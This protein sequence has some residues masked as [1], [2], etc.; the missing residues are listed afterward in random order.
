M[1][2]VEDLTPDQIA[3]FRETFNGFDQDGD[4]KITQDEFIH[5]MR[6]W[7]QNPTEEE[8]QQMFD[9]VDKDR[10]GYIEFD[11]YLCLM[12]S[13]LQKVDTEDDY[14]NAFKEFD[15]DNDGKITKDELKLILTNLGEKIQEV[16]I[17]D[18]IA[19]ADPNN[20]GLID[21]KALVHLMSSYL[22]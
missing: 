19:L 17:N 11:E 15:E 16:E 6:S 9:A 2:K 10:N 4:G 13:K 3:Q 12:C 1:T 14:V 20:D 18:L 5:I 8:G 21:Y 22:E 7:G